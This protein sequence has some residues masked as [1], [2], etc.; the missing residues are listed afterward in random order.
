L[1]QSYLYADALGSVRMLSDS[2][3]NAVESYTYD[4]YGRPQ[5]MRAAGPDGNWL[6]EDT[7]RDTVSFIG[8]P[9]MFTGRRW[10]YQ[11]GLYYYRFRDYSPDL[12]RFMQTD[13]AG[14]IDRM[15]LY[16]YC[17]NNPLNWLDPW[18]L[19]TILGVH[20]NVGHAW[21]SVNK[22]GNIT[23]YGLWHSSRSAGYSAMRPGSDLYKNRES[24]YGGMVNRYYKLNEKQEVRLEK[25]LAKKHKYCMPLGIP[26]H[27]CSSFASDT[28]KK[29]VGEDVNADD[30]G[31]RG[32][33]TPAELGRSI[34]RLEKVDP[35][36]SLAPK[37]AP[38]DSGSS[39]LSSSS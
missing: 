17:G 6:T 39:S 37:D 16:A 15:N 19:E 29:V 3:G 13:P 35:T 7:I 34:L 28:V 20:A 30:P 33:E 8:N 12:G 14:Y 22:D 24:R 27:N 10:D 31:A 9:Y 2:S 1:K 5:V 26:T 21:I 36:S 18:G 23:T 38:K 4:P 11:T 25:W 32:I